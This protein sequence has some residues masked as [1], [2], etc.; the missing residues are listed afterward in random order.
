MIDDQAT[1]ASDN[2][3]YRTPCPPPRPAHN[4]SA[5]GTTFLQSCLVAGC[6]TV[7]VPVLL[8]GGVMLVMYLALSSSLDSMESGSFS[9][10]VQSSSGEPNLRERVL[11]TGAAGAGT[12]AVVTVHGP[13]T[14]NGSSLDG[15]G[16][17]GYVSQQLRAAARSS[18]V[19][20]VILQ[21]DSPGGG[22]TASDLLHHEVELL[23]RRG[24]PV[25]AWS[26]STMA[27]GGYYIAVA[28]ESVM[29]SPTTTIGSIGVILQ[30]FQVQ[31]LLGK[32]G[33]RVDPVTSG[34]HKDLGSPFRA[35]TPEERRILEDY[36]A[37]A[38]ARFV[39]IVAEGRDLPPE[40][41]REVADGRIFDPTF[42]L[43][44]GL[45]DS[46]GYIE[47]A[48]ALAENRVGESNMRIIG[49]R[50]QLSLGDLFNEAGAGA[51]GAAVRAAREE[52]TPQTM[53]VW[54]GHAVH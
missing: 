29:A 47:D 53:A 32:L 42:A 27:S 36:I 9:S 10:L 17:L 4:R 7:L 39:A 46:I 30:H 34:E 2:A 40:R 25:I 13:I 35:M 41:V 54:D 43:E 31:E 37:V 33:I 50:R 3:D 15:T 12:L 24:K 45:I 14:G 52:T 23:R 28:A 1:P 51:A 22:L 48:V 11:R 5:L 20:A 21:I 8:I 16:S 49:Y 26:G 44:R 38:H 18:A 19:K 6:V